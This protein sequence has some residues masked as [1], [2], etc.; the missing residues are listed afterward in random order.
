MINLL[1]NIPKVFHAIRDI[2][3]L[4]EA[5]SKENDII[6]NEIK[7]NELDQFIETATARGVERREKML[8]IKP[9]ATDS[10]DDRKFRLYARYNEELPF[11]FKKLKRALETLCGVDGVLVKEDE[12]Q[13]SITTKVALTAKSNFYDV[14]NMLERMVPLNMN[15]YLSLMY[16]THEVL[17]SYTHSALKSYT[18]DQLRNEVLK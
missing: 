2:K 10:L 13:C 9:K 4:L 7:N 8:N 1:S 18:N 17:S 3:I 12:I 6:S 14:S 11:T 16:N 15:I 5:E